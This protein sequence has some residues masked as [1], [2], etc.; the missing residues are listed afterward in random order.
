[1]K[2]KKTRHH[3]IPRSKGGNDELRNIS[4]VKQ[5]THNHYHNL[6]SNMTPVEILRYLF[7]TFWNNDY[8]FLYEFL[9]EVKD[10]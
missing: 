6:F 7:K 5:K 4:W 9:Q 8:T 1:V 10:E 3:I 2:K